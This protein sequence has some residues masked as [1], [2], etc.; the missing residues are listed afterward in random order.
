[1]NGTQEIDL[2]RPHVEVK[3]APVNLQIEDIAYLRTLT[4]P[5]NLRC[6]PG[7]KTLAKLRFLDLIGRAKVGPKPE[8]TAA[9]KQLVRS[10]KPKLTDALKREDW[11]EVGNIVYKLRGEQTRLRPIEDDVLTERGKQLLAQGNATVRVRK[12]GCVE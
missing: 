3:V 8:E 7:H 6:H 2:S 4:Q 1:M 10:S 11:E 9:Y 12:I 5:K